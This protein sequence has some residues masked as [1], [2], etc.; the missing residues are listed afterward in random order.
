MSSTPMIVEG[1]VVAPH[2]LPVAST[3]SNAPRKGKRRGKGSSGSRQYGFEK[4]KSTQFHAERRS[5]LNASLTP[6]ITLALQH[7][8]EQ[9]QQGSSIS[10]VVPVTTRGI[11]FLVQIFYNDAERHISRVEMPPRSSIH[12]LYRLSLMQLA[13]QMVL[14]EAGPVH[15]LAPRTPTRPRV[16][17]FAMHQNGVFIADAIAQIGEFVY[18]GMRHHT[19]VPDLYLSKKGKKRVEVPTYPQS[20]PAEASPLKRSADGASG[21]N[22][23]NITYVDHNYSLPDPYC[24]TIYNLRSAVVLL[25]NEETPVEIRRAFFSRNPIP[26]AM[27]VNNLLVNPGDVMPI[28]YFQY[29]RQQFLQDIDDCAALFSQMSA[30]NATCLGHVPMDGKGSDLCLVTVRTAPGQK[31]HVSTDGV[32]S[33]GDSHVYASHTVSHLNRL[34]AAVNLMT[35]MPLIENYRTFVDST[36]GIRDPSLAVHT[37]VE[38]WPTLAWNVSPFRRSE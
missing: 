19:Y 26:G 33:D 18:D 24:I 10:R 8:L 34:R 11:G 35:E 29:A 30:A 36:F 37:F 6:T 21:S 27:I 4:N 9:N 15:T 14:A 32:T 25:S 38:H 12:Q 16:G 1:E 17:A 23:S 28:E 22:V 31:F 5:Q 3:S 20:P 13:R 7:Y 2:S